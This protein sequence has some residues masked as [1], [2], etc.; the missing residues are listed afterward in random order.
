M[1]F[2]TDPVSQ[3]RSI[4]MGDFNIDHQL[5]FVVANEGTDNIGIFLNNDNRTFL[6]Q[7]RYQTGSGSRPYSVSVADLN[8]DNYLDIIV[9]NYGKETVS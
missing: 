3:P 4:A 9:A 6:N 8:N 2:S 5:D 7:T 1:T